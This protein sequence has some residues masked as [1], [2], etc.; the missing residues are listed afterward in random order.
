M[1][2][3]QYDVLMD[4]LKRRLVKLLAAQEGRA[5]VRRVW[6]KAHT[7]PEHKVTGHYRTLITLRARRARKEA[8]RVAA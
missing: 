1:T 6:V 2:Q 7:V 8:A 5:D 3:K 4:R